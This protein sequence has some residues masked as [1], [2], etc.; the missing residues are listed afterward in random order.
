VLAELIEYAGHDIPSYL[1]SQSAKEGQPPIEVGMERVVREDINFSYCNAIVAE[2][3][4]KVAAMMLAYRLPEHSDVDLDELPLAR[5][6]AAEIVRSRKYRR[7]ESW[8]DM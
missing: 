4:G 3:E 2:E 8:D 5:T 1:W 7:F 6:V